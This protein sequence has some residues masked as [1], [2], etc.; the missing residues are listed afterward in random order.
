MP[1]SSSDV[2]RLLCPN[3]FHCGP[4]SGFVPPEV[5]E[6]SPFI[7]IVEK[8]KGIPYLTRCSGCDRLAVR[9][10]QFLHPDCAVFLDA[11]GMADVPGVSP[12]D[13]NRRRNL[14]ADAY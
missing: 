6:T 4:Q 9:R 12:A 10:L 8:Y 5:L 7:K 3:P 1:L 13:G 14:L 11:T 2:K